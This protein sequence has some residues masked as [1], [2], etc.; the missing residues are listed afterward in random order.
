LCDSDY[1]RM[2]VAAAERPQETDNDQRDRNHIVQQSR[3]HKHKNAALLRSHCVCLIGIRWPICR[4]QYDSGSTQYKEY[5]SHD[6][7]ESKYAAADVHVDLQVVRLSGH[8]NSKRTT[9][10]GRYRT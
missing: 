10:S 6:Q 5:E 4:S 7:N 8:W 9:P 1:C 3:H 2:K